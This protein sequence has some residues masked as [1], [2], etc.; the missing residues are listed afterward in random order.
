MI[1]N[2][3]G[4]FID[5]GQCEAGAIAHV[6]VFSM[7]SCSNKAKYRITF[8]NGRVINV[9]GTH[10]RQYYKTDWYDKPIKGEFIKT[11]K[12]VEETKTNKVIY[13]MQGL[14]SGLPLQDI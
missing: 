2:E 1:K 4:Y 9:C 10:L 5:E 11:V 7:T 3:Y 6:R 12:K 14:Y 8:D 13:E